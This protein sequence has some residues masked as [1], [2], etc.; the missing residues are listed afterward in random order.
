M[1]LSRRRLPL[2]LAAAALALGTAAG[3]SSSPP[4]ITARGTLTVYV[5]LLSGVSLQ[6]AYPDISD[7][8]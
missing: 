8:G 6:D 3:C 1:T 7:G 2:A 5:G 4:P